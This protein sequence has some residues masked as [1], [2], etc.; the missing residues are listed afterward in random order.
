MPI[1]SGM[2]ATAMPWWCRTAVVGATPRAKRPGLARRRPMARRPW[3]GCVARAGAMARWGVTD[4]P[5]RA[6]PSCCWRTPD[7]AS[8]PWRQPWL[9]WMN[10][11]TGPARAVPIGGPCSWPGPCNWQRWPA[12]AATITRP[13]RRSAPASTPAA[14]WARGRPC[15]SATTPAPW[16]WLGCGATPPA[17][18]AGPAISRPPRSG[19][20]PCC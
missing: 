3:P 10:G 16:G 5:T 15:S 18:P 11:C 8:M 4:F 6:S 19:V 13:G 12:A 1:P 7:P 9:A 20:N 2:R 17:A 14:S